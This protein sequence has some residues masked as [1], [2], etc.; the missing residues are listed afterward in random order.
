MSSATIDY[1]MPTFTGL[2]SHGW[3]GTLLFRDGSKKSDR[4]KRQS[5]PEENHLLDVQVRSGDYFVTLATTLDSLSRNI[6]DYYIRSNIEDLVSDLIHLQD[7]YSII[8]H[9]K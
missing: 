1:T 4:D 6:E 2:M 8:K 3:S 7:N 5:T 9:K